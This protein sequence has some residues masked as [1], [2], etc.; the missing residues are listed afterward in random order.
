MDVLQV[1][2]MSVVLDEGQEMYGEDFV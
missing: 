1:S 2:S